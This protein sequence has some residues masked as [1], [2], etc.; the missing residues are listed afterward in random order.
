MVTTL[1]THFLTGFLATGLL[2]VAFLAAAFLAA[3]LLAADLTGLAGLLPALV[4]E[5]FTTFLADGLFEVFSADFFTTFLVLAFSSPL[6]LLVE[7]VLTFLGVAFFVTA[8]PSAVFFTTFFFLGASAFFFTTS[9][10]S[11]GFSDFSAPT[12]AIL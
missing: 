6:A 4:A 12:L 1:L 3:G 10:F 8:L 5:P 7:P 2:A 9:T 11:L